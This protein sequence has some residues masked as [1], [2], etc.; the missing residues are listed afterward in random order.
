MVQGFGFRF[1]VL[2]FR[3]MLGFRVSFLGVRGVFVT[4]I[5]AF[6]VRFD[7]TAL[8]FPHSRLALVRNSTSKVEMTGP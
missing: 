5:L 4:G 1:R 7:M 6:S 8:H 2:G 3:M